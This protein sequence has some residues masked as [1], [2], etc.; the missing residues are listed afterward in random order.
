[1]TSPINL[2]IKRLDGTWDIIEAAPLL[3]EEGHELVPTGSY[4]LY[5]GFPEFDSNLFDFQTMRERY[6]ESLELTGEDNPGYLGELHFTG[7]GYFEWKYVGHQ[8]Q[9]GEVW[10]IVDCL[11]DYAAGKVHPMDNGI[12]LPKPEQPEDVSLYFKYGKDQIV[13]DIRLEEMEGH[14][15]VLINSDPT[16]QFELLEQDWEITGGEIDDADLLAEI[17]RRIKANT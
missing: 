2:Q 15:V 10:Q 4:Q 5:R 8:L 11:Q 9:D 7:I 12:I 16:A 17:L 3:I 14:F 13:R 6:V 1:M